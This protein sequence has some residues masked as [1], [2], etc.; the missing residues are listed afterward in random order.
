MNYIAHSRQ[1]ADGLPLCFD[2]SFPK[3]LDKNI[4]C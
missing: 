2:A 4:E 3:D 1:V